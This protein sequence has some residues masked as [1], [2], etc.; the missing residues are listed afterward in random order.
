[1]R[2]RPE[3]GRVRQSA[4]PVN[5]SIG[6]EIKKKKKGGR[7]ERRYEKK[8]RGPSHEAIVTKPRSIFQTSCHVTEGNESAAAVTTEAAMMRVISANAV[9]SK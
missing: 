8:F 7:G 4:A 1:M 6:G 9:Q 3:E 2:T 5:P